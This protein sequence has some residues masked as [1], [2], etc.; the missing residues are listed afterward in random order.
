M[1]ETKKD[2]NDQELNEVNGG[3]ALTPHGVNRPK[4]DPVPPRPRKEHETQYA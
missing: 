1:E 3:G 4:S 2:C